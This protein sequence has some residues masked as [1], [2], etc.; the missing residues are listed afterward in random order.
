MC[1][2]VLKIAKYYSEVWA[3]LVTQIVKNIPAMQETQV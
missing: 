2:D 1:R 3:F